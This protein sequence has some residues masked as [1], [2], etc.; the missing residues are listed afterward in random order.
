MSFFLLLLFFF[1]FFF[2]TLA[3]ILVSEFIF[4]MINAPSVLGN[5][6]QKEFKPSEDLSSHG[7]LF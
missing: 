1:F 6:G 5:T 2:R 4:V 7:T 3:V